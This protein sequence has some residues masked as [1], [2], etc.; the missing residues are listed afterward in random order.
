MPQPLA[1]L[2]ACALCGASVGALWPVTFS[3]AARAM[4]KGGTALFALLA[5]AGDLGC[6]AGP[7]LV[8]FIAEGAGGSL[9]A[10]L[11]AGTLFPV[12][13]FLALAAS[14]KKI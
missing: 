14:R 8:G 9:R 4:P 12:V 10:G 11:L 2:A 6:S 5:L 7:G 1:G 3:L 13:M